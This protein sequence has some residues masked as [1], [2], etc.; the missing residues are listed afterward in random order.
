MTKFIATTIAKDGHLVLRLS[1]NDNVVI[2]TLK[3]NDNRSIELPPGKYW[4][5]WWF[6]SNKPAEYT[7]KV[8]TDPSVSPLPVDH[9]YKYSGPHDD[10]KVPFSFIINS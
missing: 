3:D 2:M 7:I 4:V 5:E 8:D 9:T 6:W 10:E 1:N